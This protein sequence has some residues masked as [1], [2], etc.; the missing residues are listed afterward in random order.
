MRTIRR[1]SR[2]LNGTKWAALVELAGRYAGEKDD[3]LR[4]FNADGYFARTSWRERRDALLRSGYASPHRLQGRMWKMALKDAFETAGKQWSALAADLRSRIRQ[5]NEWS[6]VQR[7]YAFWLLRIPQRVAGMSVGRAPVPAHFAV[8][9]GEQR[10]VRNYLRRVMRRV[11]GRRPRVAGAR[12]LSLDANMYTVFQEGGTQYIKVMGLTPGQRL[13]IPLTG[14]TPIRGNVRLVLDEA[15]RRI[16]VHYPTEMKPAS[17]L[18]GEPCGLDAGVTEVFTDE[19]GRRYGTGFG[20]LLARESDRLKEKGVRRNRLHQVEKQARAQGDRRKARRLRRRNLGRRKLQRQNRL[21]RTEL[22][23]QVNTAVN[24][25]LRERQPAVI[26]T[27]RLDIRG[28]A[29]SK[30]LSRQ[31]SLWARSLL[32]ERVEFKASAGGSR[33]EQVN[34]AYS[35]QTCPTCGFVHRGNRRGDAFQCLACGHADAADRVAAH[36]LKARLADDQVRP[37]TPGP[38]VKAILL[39]RFNA[40]LESPGDRA[41][42][43]GWT[44]GVGPGWTAG[45]PESETTGAILPLARENTGARWGQP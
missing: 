18:T 31:V 33:R 32:K 10:Q 2:R 36:N 34:P 6:E 13:T 22:A 20:A 16:E 41:T 39:A 7:H 30:R 17:P 44:P 43:S 14:D 23:R 15:E 28:K 9:V 38:V 42:V 5:K 1:V 4:A 40:R 3:H 35:S 37:W 45:Q 27:E 19:E 26:V 8:G 11:R 12:S 24:Q 29:R 21:A 25:V